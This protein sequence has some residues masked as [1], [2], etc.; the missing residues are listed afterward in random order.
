[1][2]FKVLL[3]VRSLDI[4]DLRIFAKV[5]EYGSISRA[6]AEMNYVQSNVTARIQSLEKKLH[7]PLFI[8]HKR[9]MTLNSEG[10]RL[11]E[12]AE[13]ILSSM[14]QLEDMFRESS[15]PCGIM[16]IGIVETIAALPRLLSS[17]YR[18]HPNVELS[19]HTGVT[20]QLMQDVLNMKLDGAF[21]SGPVRHPLIEQTEVSQENLLL[22]SSRSNFRL[23]DM[24]STPLLLYKEGCGY[25][26]RLKSWMQM[27]GIVCKRVMEFGTFGTIMGSVS[28]G[29]GISVFP[30]SAIVEYASKEAIYCHP[31]PEPYNELTTVF[32]QRKDVYVTNTVRS[33]MEEILSLASSEKE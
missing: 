3:E 12:H 30:E 22:V 6:A 31:I 25:R 1:M 33:L 16:D 9:G 18:K 4:H 17:Y 26:E 21:V 24:A 15:E 13:D 19:L 27:E 2:I 10:R 8:R 23:E 5:A 29:I 20:E 11:L 32:I 14:D 7:T 28:A